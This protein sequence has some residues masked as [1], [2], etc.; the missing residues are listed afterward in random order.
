MLTIQSKGAVRNEGR[1]FPCCNHILA[2]SSIKGEKVIFWP[3][4]NG[5]NIP[6]D[7]IK[8]SQTG[9][10]VVEQQVISIQN[11]FR[12]LS[13]KKRSRG[14]SKTIIINLKKMRTKNRSL[15]N[16]WG[17]PCST[18]KFTLNSYSL[19]PIS[20]I[21]SYPLNQIGVKVKWYELLQ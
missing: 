16:P 6:L 10:C 8:V 2:F 19:K 20:Q 11:T 21:I 3:L 7:I 14:V 1:S 18:W 17:N 4:L 9:Y 12:N 5:T 15:W 13:H